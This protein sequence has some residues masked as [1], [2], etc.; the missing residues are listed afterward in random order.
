MASPQQ[1]ASALLS[2]STAPWALLAATLLR[3]GCCQ[4][5]APPRQLSFTYKMCQGK[6]I[7]CW[8]WPSCVGQG[9]RAG[10]A[11]AHSCRG[12]EPAWPLHLCFV[13]FLFPHY[14]SVA[15]RGMSSPGCFQGKSSFSS[16]PHITLDLFPKYFSLASPVPV[17]SEAGVFPWS[18][19]KAGGV[20]VS[21]K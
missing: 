13:G 20:L 16:L 19:P 21:R 18:W 4:P 17:L 2:A 7:D 8:G 14:I 6:E 5:P 10:L 1:L 15:A 9:E 12:L 3:R 11:A